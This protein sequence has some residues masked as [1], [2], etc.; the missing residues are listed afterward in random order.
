MIK[1]FNQIE[2]SAVKEEK[3]KQP[4]KPGKEE[5]KASAS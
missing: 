3:R 1:K 4:S 5:K 2:E